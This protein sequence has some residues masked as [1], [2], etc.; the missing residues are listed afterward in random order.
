MSGRELEDEVMLPVRGVRDDEEG[1]GPKGSSKSSR[2]AGV[3]VSYC[4]H[5]ADKEGRVR[6]RERACHRQGR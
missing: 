4:E 5:E 6:G 2:S 1:V 3:Q